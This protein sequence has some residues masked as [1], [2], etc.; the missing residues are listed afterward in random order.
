MYRHVRNHLEV[1]KIFW[2]VFKEGKRMMSDSE[3]IITR[4]LNI[5]ERKT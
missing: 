5:K 1:S 4:L 3:P 2:L